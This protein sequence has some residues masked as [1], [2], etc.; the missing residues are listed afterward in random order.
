MFMT[1]NISPSS[2][3]IAMGVEEFIDRCGI[4]I[5]DA[6][7]T[8]LLFELVVK[9]VLVSGLAGKR[10]AHDTGTNVDLYSQ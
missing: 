1:R 8:S 3:L 9:F 10:H 6:S 7:S 5:I 2:H 4:G